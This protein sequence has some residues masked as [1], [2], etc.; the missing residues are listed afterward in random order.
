MKCIDLVFTLV[1]MALLCSGSVQAQKQ[2]KEQ[3][4]PIFSPPLRVFISAPGNSSGFTA[5]GQ[6]VR[7]RAV[8]HLKQEFTKP[9]RGSKKR[10]TDAVTDDKATADIVLEVVEV[11]YRSKEDRIGDALRPLDT[12]TPG[13]LMVFRIKLIVGD[14]YSTVIDAVWN[15]L[16]IGFLGPEDDYEAPAIDAAQQVYAWA[17]DNRDKLLARRRRDP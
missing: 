4:A 11:G 16:P 14:D 5:P 13:M 12:K 10:D 3:P 7:D 2:K 6:S 9:P 17:Y 8:N 1:L 15:G